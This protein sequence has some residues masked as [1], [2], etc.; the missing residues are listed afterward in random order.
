MITFAISKL[1]F[2]HLTRQIA[3]CD[4]IR[5]I[6]ESIQFQFIISENQYSF[7]KS[8]FIENSILTDTTFFSPCFSLSQVDTVDI[9]DDQAMVS[10]S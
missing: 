4:A 6:N 3:L 7:F 8:Y 1:G 5:G 10:R 2:G 9:E